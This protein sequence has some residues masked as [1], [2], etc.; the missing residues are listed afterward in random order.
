VRDTI[1]R[2]SD[3]DASTMKYEVEPGSGKYR[4]GTIHFHAKKGKSIDLEAI[5]KSLQKTRLSGKTRSAVNYL[6]ITAEGTVTRVGKAMLL[7]VAGTGREFALTEDPKSKPKNGDKTPLE[8]LRTALATGDKV[9]SVTGRVEGWSG[10]WPA[11]LRELPGGPLDDSVEGAT[12]TA[13]QLPR[14]LVTDFQTSKE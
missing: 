2:Q 5:H 6:E 9:V 4:N 3:V 11:V 10:P 14:L 12:G 8:R 1:A 13:R 7:K